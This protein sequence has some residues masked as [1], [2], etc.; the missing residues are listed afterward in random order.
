MSNGRPPVVWHLDASR[1]VDKFDSPPDRL[2]LVKWVMKIYESNLI[3]L[4]EAL[5]AFERICDNDETNTEIR[6]LLDKIKIN[7][8]TRIDEVLKCLGILKE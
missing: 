1:I 7:A 3:S 8:E 6:T 4:N 2:T 5:I